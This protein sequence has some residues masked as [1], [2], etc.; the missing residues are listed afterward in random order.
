[1]FRA[2]L[3]LFILLA[4]PLTAANRHSATSA[5]P[6][7]EILV[8]KLPY[9]SL[10]IEL[11]DPRTQIEKYGNG[12]IKFLSTEQLDIVYKFSFY[13][14]DNLGGPEKI[15]TAQRY[16][17]IQ[18]RLYLEGPSYSFHFEGP[19]HTENHW[20]S[21]RMNGKQARFSKLGILLE[22]R[23]YESGFPT[24][25]WALYHE[26]GN[27]ARSIRFPSS[28]AIW[29]E[30]EQLPYKGDPHSQSLH[31]MPYLHPY[32]LMESW[33]YPNGSK[34]KDI[35]IKGYKEGSKV[36]IVREGRSTDFT[37]SGKIRAHKKGIHG[38]A[39]ERRFSR[40]LNVKYQDSS[41]WFD[42][43]VFKVVHVA[44]PIRL[45]KGMQ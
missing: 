34:Q 9:I 10:S 22:K 21:G 19:V 37:K 7:N 43:R 3:I 13:Q 31:N 20:T 23:F 41:E 28:L 1:M 25:N 33:Y 17:N 5:N 26:N 44:E 12:R 14:D 32:A 16:K 36:V 35:H 18:D 15:R 11:S 45:E 29:R 24:D 40:S 39:F 27:L 4:V 8:L 6:T 30:T 2:A 38:A 42:D